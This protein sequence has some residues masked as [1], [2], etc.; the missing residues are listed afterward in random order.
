MNYDEIINNLNSIF[1]YKGDIHDL[2]SFFLN[3]KE[4]VNEYVKDFNNKMKLKKIIN[5]NS[6]FTNIY[7]AIINEKIMNNLISIND[8][9]CFK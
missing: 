3:H 6:E 1:L 8:L 2:D 7:F 4:I 9:D 5:F